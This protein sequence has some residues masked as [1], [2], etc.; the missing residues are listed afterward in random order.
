MLMIDKNSKTGALV[1]FSFHLFILFLYMINIKEIP[2]EK[3]IEP[4]KISLKE[5]ELP[6]I[7]SYSKAK[8]VETIQNSEVKKISEPLEKKIVQPPLKEETAPLKES[9]LEEIKSQEIVS[10]EKIVTKTDPIE[11]DFDSAEFE[12]TNFKS[13]RDAIL[14]NLQ[15]PNSAK[16][17]KIQGSVEV[18]L[19]IDPNG[20]LI[21]IYLE[22]SSGYEILDNSAIKAATKLYLEALPIPKIVTKVTLP[23]NFVID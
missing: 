15:Y 18:T 8:E 13:I 9:I 4:I 19:V 3:L 14:K 21:D 1:S 16:R 5:L 7:K 20:K 6:T 11:P 22:K 10:N 17:M 12:K 2:Q 23:I